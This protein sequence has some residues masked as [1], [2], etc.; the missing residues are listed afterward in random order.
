MSAPLVKGW[1]PGAYRPMMSG[2]GLLVR[3]RPWLGQLDAAQVLGLCEAA[4]RFGNGAIDLTS[5]ANLQIR[6]VTEADHPALINTLQKLD[7]LDADPALEERRNVVIAPD[8]QQGDVSHQ[9]G[10]RLYDALKDLP[11]LPA[12]MGFAIDTGKHGQLAGCSADFRFEKTSDG[13]LIL[14]AD[15]APKGIGVTID[16]AMEK[17]RR[18]MTWFVESGGN[19]LGR[20]S[21]H[22]KQTDLPSEWQELAPRRDGPLPTPGTSPTGRVLGVPFGQIVAGFLAKLMRDSKSIG[23]R[24]MQGRL[25][26]LIGGNETSAH[27]FVTE[28]GDPMLDVHACP[29]APYCPQAEAPTRE[30]ARQ[31]AYEI[32]KGASLH[33][34]GCTK[35]CAFPRH[36]D[37]TLVGTNGQVNLVRDGAPWDEPR[38]MEL[39]EAMIQ[40]QIERF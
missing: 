28:R 12:K 31:L 13:Q 15:G 35:G 36:A 14:R 23:F 25:V 4:E 32:P 21:R 30:L 5:R 7:L 26:L 9:L 3:I 24:P 38:E 10:L 37:F 33:V 40:Q 34:S 11:T 6:G 18:L 27:D 19:T 2:D 1:C 22:L 39:T 20:M 29:G 17:L 16:T 8:W